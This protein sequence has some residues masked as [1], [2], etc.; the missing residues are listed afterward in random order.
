MMTFDLCSNM[1]YLIRE[2]K[3]LWHAWLAILAFY[4]NP[5]WLS[6]TV[7]NHNAI[8]HAMGVVKKSI[9]TM[10]L[11]ITVLSLFLSH[12]NSFRNMKSRLK[13]L[14]CCWSMAPSPR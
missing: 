14:P 11:L 3:E 8:E 10:V 9:A 7:T 5:V 1:Q 4:F 6:N 12:L 2:F 13:F